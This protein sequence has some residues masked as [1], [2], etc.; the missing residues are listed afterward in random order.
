[1]AKSSQRI[2]EEMLKTGF[3][4]IYKFGTPEKGYE[5][6]FRRRNSNVDVSYHANACLYPYLFTFYKDVV[7][8]EGRE[9]E[10]LWNSMWWQVII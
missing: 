4:L 2:E 6:S 1:M 9:R 10:F 8:S 5:L 7:R 3:K